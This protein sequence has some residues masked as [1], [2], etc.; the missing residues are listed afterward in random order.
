[1]GHLV[2]WDIIRAVEGKDG[3]TQD[4]EG[5]GV[6]GEDPSLRSKWERMLRDPSGAALQAGVCYAQFLPWECC[7]LN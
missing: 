1:M 3:G 6:R 2:S 5:L 4:A 7:S